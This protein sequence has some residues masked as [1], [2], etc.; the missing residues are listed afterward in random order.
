VTTRK[1]PIWVHLVGAAV[2]CA[3]AAYWAIRLLAPAPA[4][5]PM[6]PAAEITRDADPRLA[7]RLL[8]DASGGQFALASNVQVYGV[9]AAGK[10][11]SAVVS[12]DGKPA[13]AV[14][15]GQ[16]LAPGMRL[17]GVSGDRI[18]I[19]RDGVQS[20]AMVPPL[21]TARS[22]APVAGFRREGN[23]LTAPS[24]DSPV[25][26]GPPRVGFG[27]RP[28][29]PPAPGMPPGGPRAADDPNSRA[30]AFVPAASPPPGASPGG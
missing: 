13:R 23:V 9:F 21:A 8:G 14:F 30:P 24:I 6:A 22:S 4:S 1:T 11:S 3:M 5:A 29:V 2:A 15:L 18:S 7:A 10:D 25:A 26:V 17:V 27:G 19:E 28:G 20:E 16:D 12:V